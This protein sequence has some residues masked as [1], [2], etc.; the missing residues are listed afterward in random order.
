MNPSWCP[1]YVL[2]PSSRRKLHTCFESELHLSFQGYNPNARL[3]RQKQKNQPTKKKKTQ[4]N[5]NKTTKKKS[6]KKGQ[7]EK[8]N[9]SKLLAHLKHRLT[10]Y[11][12]DGTTVIAVAITWALLPPSIPWSPEGQSRTSTLHWSIKSCPQM[13]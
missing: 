10:F 3:I 11:I 8:K 9:H 12:K 4:T 1:F 13:N 6:Q 7:K 5:K 2:C